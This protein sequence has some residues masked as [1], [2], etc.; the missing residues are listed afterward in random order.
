M[1]VHK[2]PFSY[3]ANPAGHFRIRDANDNA[4]C[5]CYSEG[6]AQ[7][8]V[9]R[10]N[11]LL[12]SERSAKPALDGIER[13]RE[14][15]AADF[16]SD[17]PWPQGIYEKFRVERTDGKSAPGEKHDG[18]E[19][20]VLD[21]DH[22]KHAVAAVE[23]Y[24]DSCATEYPA[25][26]ADLRYNAIRMRENFGLPHSASREIPA[27]LFDGMAVYVAL[28]ENSG[29]SPRDVAAVLDVVVRLIRKNRG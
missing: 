10:L 14:R 23:A 16:P 1:N 9:Q 13:M 15:I 2:A 6:N 20:F 5:F 25:L 27:E 4:L 28:G 19:Y 21:F 26:A 18:C 3:E 12:P 8:V 11:A 22:D 24:A 7:E 29:I 17:P